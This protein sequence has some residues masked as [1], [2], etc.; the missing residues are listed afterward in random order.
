ML[1][2]IMRIPVRKVT[3]SKIQQT[4]FSVLRFGET[5]SDHMAIAEYRDGSWHQPEIVPYGPILVHPSLSIFHYGQGVFEGMKAFKT[6]DGKINIFRPEKHYERFVRSCERMCIPVID[7]DVFMS[8]LVELIQLDRDWIPGEKFKS[9]YLRPFVIAAEEYLGLRACTKY[10][11]MVITGPVGNYYSTGINPVSL[12]TMP[13]YV[14]AVAGGVGD[15]KVPGNY[16]S[17][18]LP[19]QTAQEQG[20]TQ[21][22]WLDAIEHKYVEEV[23]SMNMC[24]VIGG[25]LIS[26]PL[27]G[28]ILPGV[29]RDAVLTL[30]RE[31]GMEVEERP[32][33]I[34][35]IIY[36]SK[37]GSLQEA[38]GTGTAAVISPV[39]KI[40]H[41]GTHIVINN[42]EFG[43]IARKFYDYITSL[44]HGEVEDTHGWNMIVE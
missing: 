26:P 13:D 9:L 31:W 44:H 7:K 35:E 1:Q 42:N 11:F 33:S 27:R 3:Q 36:A 5:F 41:N 23:G 4:D 32:V 17:A 43:D 16:A 37:D 40:H 2:D 30:A 8:M 38:F 29:T 21:V 14:R 10:K 22:M 34:D 28:S 25:K 15:A 19:T 6:V 24:F 12:T 20:Y 18:L 39:G